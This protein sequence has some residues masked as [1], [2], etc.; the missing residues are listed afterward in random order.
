MRI[1]A[2][3]LFALA[4]LCSANAKPNIVVIMAD[5]LGWRDL[6]CYG[7]ASVDTP[8]L[9][10][11]AADGMRFTDAY[12]ASPVCTPTRA[13]MMTGQSPARLRITNHAPGNPD[14]FAL[15]GSS[16][17]EAPNIR[18]LP[19]AAVTIAERLSAAGYATAH[20][21][22]WHLSHVVRGDKR[23]AETDLRPEKQ[24]FDL[25]AGG[26]SSGGPASYFAPYRNSAFKDG[27]D[28]EYLP[29]RLADEAIRFI[30]Q[31]KEQSFYLN[32]WP[33]SVHY[34]MQ[35][36][37]ALIAKYRQRTEIK[38]PIYAAMIEGLDTAIGSFLKALDE[39]GLRENTL[40]L[41]KSDNGGYHGDN[42]PLRGFK[43]MLYEGGIRIPWI[44][45]W[46]GQVPPGTL[47]ST[48]VISTDC[49]PTLLE[50]AGLPPTEAH[51]VDGKS[52]LPLLTQTSGFQRETLYFHYPNYAFHKRNRLGSALREGR[53]KLIQ[54]YD[55]H[56]LELYDLGSDIGEKNNLAAQAPDLTRRL[57]EKLQAWLVKS[58]AQLPARH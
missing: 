44:V 55:D 52:L 53:Y 6:H 19:L 24:G 58:E 25:N 23:L 18:H 17:H 34:P 45:R 2:L 36:R 35:A 26:N 4:G 10:Q 29:D 46:P 14:G 1:A 56:S 40:V 8:T 33:Y 41:F 30:R 11:L 5:D 3:I 15:E 49:Y 7:N 13:A 9:D 27:Q 20:V 32:W 54:N 38:D 48:P 51:P 37:E 39:A 28:G 31:H 42:R 16:L 50:V 43:G 57:A 47:N 22:K 21:G 12:A